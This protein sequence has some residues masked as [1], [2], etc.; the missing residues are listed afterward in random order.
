MGRLNGEAV[1]REVAKVSSNT[2]VYIASTHFH[3]EHTTGYHGFPATAQYINSTTQEAEFAELGAGFIERFAG[4]SPMQAE[5]L[6][7]AT[8]RT[9]DITFDREYAL[10]L[11][12]VTVRFLVVGPTHT[13]GD[14]GFFVEGDNVLYAGDVVMNQSFVSA[15]ANSSIEAWLAAFDAFEEMDPQSIVP[16]HGP[17]GDGSL[18]QTLRTIMNGIVT[19]TRELKANGQTA[20]QIAMALQTEF[21]QEHPTWARANGVAAIA[22]VAFDSAP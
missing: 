18:I 13:R 12:G 14:T 8:G 16:A 10:D 22:R 5:L 4:R 2:E 11:G 17:I 20:D 15:N 9:A 21:E 7:D 19:D 6:E 1:L 3:P